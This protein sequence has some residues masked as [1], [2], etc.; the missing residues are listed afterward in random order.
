MLELK[1]EKPLNISVYSPDTNILNTNLIVAVHPKTTILRLLQYVHYQLSQIHSENNDVELNDIESYCLKYMKRTISLDTSV[2]SLTTTD[3]IPHIS[4]SFE[5]S[6]AKAFS[7]LN[8]QYDPVTDF[9]T[10]NIKYEVNILSKYKFFHNIEYQVPLDT[11]VSRLEKNALEHLI[12]EEQFLNHDNKCHLGH[13]HTLESFVALKLNGE[14]D[15]IQLTEETRYFYMDL[16]LKDL[17][18]IDFAPLKDNVITIMIYAKH[19]QSISDLNDI[20]VLELISNSKLFQNHMLVDSRTTVT[21][22]RQ[23]VCDVY[24]ASQ[25][26]SL[27]DV[28]LV[29]KGQLV[30]DK[31]FAENDATILSYIDMK[32]GSQ[33]HVQVSVQQTYGQTDPFWSEPGLVD[34]IPTQVHQKP[35]PTPTVNE[36][37]RLDTP[38]ALNTNEGMQTHF[39]TE[40]GRP[41]HVSPHLLNTDT[42]YVEATLEDINGNSEAVLISGEVLNKT[43]GNILIGDHLNIDVSTDGH[44][45]IIDRRHNVIRINPRTIDHIEQLTGSSIIYHGVTRK[46]SSDSNTGITTRMRELLNNELNNPET[47]QRLESLFN[48]PTPLQQFQELSIWQKMIY[49]V[50]KLFQLVK[51]CLLTVVYLVWYMFIPL[52]ATIEIGFFLPPI[53]TISIFVIYTVVIFFRSSK[54]TDMWTDFLGLLRLNEEDYKRVK[55]FAL[56]EYTSIRTLRHEDRTNTSQMTKK[57]YEK[58]QEKSSVYSLFLLPALANVRHSLYNQYQINQMGNMTEEDSLKELF[59]QIKTGAVEINDANRMLEILFMLHELQAFEDTKQEY[60]FYRILTAIKQE[61]DLQNLEAVEPV[62]RSIIIVRRRAEQ[63]PN[64]IAEF[65]VPDPLRDDYVIAVVKNIILCLVLFFPFVSK[66]ID[67]V[68]QERVDERTRVR[69]QQA[70]EHQEQEQ[71]LDG[72]RSGHDNAFNTNEDHESITELDS[73]V[74]EEIAPEFGELDSIGE[75]SPEEEIIEEML[76]NSDG[77]DDIVNATGAMFHTQP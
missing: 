59:R 62:R 75:L 31:N 77:G 71:E 61:A 54:I 41:I 18:H 73:T 12:Y 65:I 69:L 32:H 33:L 43:Q 17:L 37:P 20:T 38:I 72:I 55:L 26:I 39:A 14:S 19:E 51:I 58:I 44:D 16:T 46:S 13:N 56:P 49:L 67:V 27:E 42:Q 74:L 25:T 70:R 47:I 21:G 45:Y 22:V 64:T 36:I 4:L 52:A 76:T 8:L 48:H 53:L 24:S 57:V 68:I 10:T 63:L 28:K 15:I 1:V 2:E 60:A 30:H 34:D 9:S 35:V 3:N 5:L 6:E 7:A 66:Y 50:K 23:F 40:S 11:K 29:Y